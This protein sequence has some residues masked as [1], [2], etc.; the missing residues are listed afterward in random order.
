[1]LGAQTPE[2]Q[3]EFLSQTIGHVHPKTVIPLY[4]DNFVIPWE[5]GGAQFNPRLVDAKPAAGFDLVIDRVERDGGRFVLLQ[6]GDRIV[7]NTCS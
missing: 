7:V 6:A 4:W 1:M 3:R 5:R 2:F